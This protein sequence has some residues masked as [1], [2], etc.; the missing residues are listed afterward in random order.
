MSTAVAEF[1][2]S[3]K[4]LKTR[5]IGISAH[6]DSGKTTL[7]ERILFYTNRIHAI[8]EVRGKDGVGAKMD[9]M[10]LERERGITIQSAATY[11]QWKN[12]TINIIDTPGHV[13]FTVEVERSLRVLDS[14]IL[15]LCGVAGVQSQSI[16]V[17]RQMRRYNVPRVA[18]INKLDRTGANPF[19]VI[20]QLKEKLKH[21]AVPVQ[22]P[23][24]LE[25]DLKG[26]VDLVTMKAYYFEGKDGMDIQEKEIPDDLK[27][28]ANKKHE[29]LLDAASMFSDELTEALLEGTPTEEMI[30][31]AIRTGTIELKIT[32]V[33]MGSA[34]K[35]K[36]VQKLLDGVL[37]YLASPVDVK[38]KALDQNNNEEMIV[39]ES[40]YEKPLVCLAFKLEDGRYGQLTYV[41]VYQGKLSKGMTIYNM[42]NN[43]KH[44][45]G[46]L[47]RMHSDE[48]EDIDSAEAGDIIALFGIDCA[49]GDTFT[50]GKL[51]VSM[52]SMFVPA[53]VISLTI[54]AKE[55]KHLNNLAKALNRFTKEDPT[56]QTHV[57][58]ESGQT[59]IKGMGELHLEVYIERMKREYGVELITGAPQVA[60]RET[61]TSKADFDY[62]HKKQTGGQGQFGRVAGYMEPIPLEETL[63]YDF[64]NKVVGGAIPREYI[65]SVDKGFKSC[66]ERGSLIGFPIIGV[67]CVIN[68]GAYHDV[69]SSDMAFQIAGRYAFRQGFNKANPQILEPIMKVE[70]DGPSEFQGA[71]LGSLNQRRGMILNTT[72]EDAYCKTEAEVPLADMFGYSTVLR[73]STQG[74]AEF[75]MEFSRYAPVPRNVAEELMKKYKVNNKDE[76]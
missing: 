54:E 51:K 55:S 18:F 69:D 25:N 23:I 70:V 24:G 53:P 7:T 40:N 75:S 61:I 14:A 2:P 50:D 60:Y 52:E 31:K 27:E 37:D 39:L 47:C 57:D 28:L 22:I 33:F 3:E 35:N 1:K 32:P 13:D 65:Q 29:E 6:I 38:N 4:L 45:V 74:K 15:V 66:L 20:E 30:K 17:D 59:I 42:S 68:D 62:T 44:N 43:K 11:C 64:V 48:M 9:S 71:I 73:S 63:D 34:F 58:P 10:D 41:R 16:T 12:H 8:H 76:D 36:G 46:R 5:N 26:V 67:R 19:R 72:E 56:F 21:N 49:S